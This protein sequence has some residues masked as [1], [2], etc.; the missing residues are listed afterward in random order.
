MQRRT[1]AIVVP[2][3]KER[4]APVQRTPLCC[5]DPEGGVHGDE[6][7]ASL[8]APLLPGGVGAVEAFAQMRVPTMQPF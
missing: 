6:E 2:R 5:C 7:L 8:G 3:A 1:E 4:S